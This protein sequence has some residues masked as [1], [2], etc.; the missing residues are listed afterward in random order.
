MI[1]PK[2]IKFVA[3]AAKEHLIQELINHIIT[4]VITSQLGLA[5]MLTIGPFIILCIIL[6]LLHKRNAA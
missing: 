6:Y 5:T 3:K 1:M 4:Y 2:T